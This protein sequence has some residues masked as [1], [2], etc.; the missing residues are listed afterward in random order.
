MQRT[1]RSTVVRPRNTQRRK[2]TASWLHG[3]R[4]SFHVGMEFGLF[5]PS[6]NSV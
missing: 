2:I 6:R 3:G 4:A 1:S 5:L